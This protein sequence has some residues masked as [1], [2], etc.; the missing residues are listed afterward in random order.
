MDE[1]GLCTVKFHQHRFVVNGDWCGYLV[2]G[3]DV[4]EVDKWKF[5]ALSRSLLSIFREV[6]LGPCNRSIEAYEKGFMWHAGYTDD[7][8]SHKWRPVQ[9]VGQG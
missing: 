4:P 7:L 2:G 9:A 5:A 8:E 1:T 3:E 6:K